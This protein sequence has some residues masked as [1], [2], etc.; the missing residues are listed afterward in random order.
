[1][2][3]ENF[4]L[5]ASEKS[6]ELEKI[7]EGW[8]KKGTGERG[9]LL[10]FASARG[11]SKRFRKPEEHFCSI[12]FIRGSPLHSAPQ[13]A[14]FKSRVS[15]VRIHRMPRAGHPAA[16]RIASTSNTGARF[17]IARKIPDS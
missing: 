2:E 3:N 7:R 9:A 12:D 6:E 17:S 13:I 4:S 1:M 14:T 15:F 8:K 16:T 11:R 10:A 5:S